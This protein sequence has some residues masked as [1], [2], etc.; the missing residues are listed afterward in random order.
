MNKDHHEKMIVHLIVFKPFSFEI[1]VFL[2]DNRGSFETKLTP[3]I[4]YYFNQE[5]DG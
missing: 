5:L 2:Q 1:T 4:H 3:D